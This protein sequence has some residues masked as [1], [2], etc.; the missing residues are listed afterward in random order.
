D[1]I[2][3]GG[4][5]GA[6]WTDDRRECSRLERAAHAV[7]R[8]MTTEADGQVAGFEDRAY[9]CP[10]DSQFFTLIGTFISS[11]LISRTNSGI[12]QATFGSTLILKWYIDCI[13]WWSSLR[14]VMRPFGVSKDMPSIAA[15]SFSVSVPPA[16][17]RASTTAMPA[18]MPP[19]V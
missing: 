18:D 6:V 5:A 16:F 7:H 3:V 19:A 2:E 15:I 8:D 10:C 9:C 13:A 1:E 4:L 17:F 14:K 12:A 11:G